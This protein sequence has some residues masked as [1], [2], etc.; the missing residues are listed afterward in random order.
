M[1]YCVCF[2]KA[3]LNFLSISVFGWVCVFNHIENKKKK[4]TRF[5]TCLLCHHKHELP[6]RW[7][8]MFYT[9]YFPLWSTKLRCFSSETILFGFNFYLFSRKVMLS[10]L[11]LHHYANFGFLSIT[12]NALG[13]LCDTEV[14]AGLFRFSTWPEVDRQ[15]TLHPYVAM[16]L[17][18][19]KPWA[20]ICCYNILHFSS[21]P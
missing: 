8:K 9:R 14:I 17:L 19:L 16:T 21:F 20:L 13:R 6:N 3:V 7:D 2:A 10:E 15:R 4:L 18:I 1:S 11:N 5:V 12:V